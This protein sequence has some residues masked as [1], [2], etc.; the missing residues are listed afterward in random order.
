M[1]V[2]FEMRSFRSMSRRKWY[3][4][5]E[6]IYVSVYSVTLKVIMSVRVFVAYMSKKK[7][8]VK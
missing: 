3:Y 4:F 6:V 5:A 1:N 8:K 7:K 2:K